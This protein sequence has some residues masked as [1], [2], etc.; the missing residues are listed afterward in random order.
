MMVDSL[1]LLANTQRS[2]EAGIAGAATT[3]F[4]SDGTRG[5][6]TARRTEFARVFVQTLLVSRSNSVRIIG[7]CRASR[8]FVEPNGSRNWLGGTAP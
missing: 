2:F 5:Q 4:P 3:C 7:T 1:T 6:M 8:P